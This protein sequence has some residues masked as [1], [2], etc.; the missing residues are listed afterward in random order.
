M[1]MEKKG[2]VLEGGGHRGIYSAG[3][4]DVLYENNVI[5]DGI[6]G[7]SAGAVHGA[8]YASGQPGRSIRYTATYCGDKRYMSM[9]SLFKT[10]NMF[11]EAF[12]YHEIPE[13]IDPYNFDA[14]ESSHTAFY[15]TCTD[16]LT[17]KPVYHLCRTLRGSEMKWMQA[18]ASM[19]LVSK[20]VEVDGH[21]MLDGGMSDSIPE[22]A[23]EKMGYTKNIVILTQ[24]AGYVKEKNTM[25]PLIK[26]ALKK[27]PALIRDMETRHIYYNRE[28]GDVEQK[29][30]KGEIL[31]IRPSAD[32]KVSRVEKDPGKILAL[33]N[34]GRQDAAAQMEAVKSFYHL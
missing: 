21:R 28:L 4:L 25:L 18:S 5:A 1:K 20:I 23:F 26:V 14:L 34:L 6:I 3:V 11:N 27:Y 32:L 29:A 30:E 7:V 8:S 9:R 22:E 12:C 16:I 31:L 2:I 19:P 13:K 17:G 10:G 15:V 33:Y 24:P